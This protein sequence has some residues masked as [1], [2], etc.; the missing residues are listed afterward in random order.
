VQKEQKKEVSASQAAITN[1]RRA[2]NIGS[3]GFRVVTHI[4]SGLRSQFTNKD[5]I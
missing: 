5:P 1:L 2:K 4:S 3:P